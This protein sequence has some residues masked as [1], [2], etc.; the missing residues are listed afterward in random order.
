MLGLCLK[1]NCFCRALRDNLSVSTVL[2]RML[3]G[4]ELTDTLAKTV[5][6]EFSFLVFHGLGD[7]S[8][9]YRAGALLEALCICGSCTAARVTVSTDKHYWAKGTGFSIGSTASKWNMDTTLARQRS[10][11]KFVYV[12]FAIMAEYVGVGEGHAAHCTQDL[13]DIFTTSCLLPAM[14]SY[15]LNDSVLDISKH[16]PLYN[17]L[18]EL[19]F[20]LASNESLRHLLMLPVYSD[21]TAVSSDGNCLSSLLAKLGTIAKTYQKTAGVETTTAIITEG[22]SQPTTSSGGSEPDASFMR[23]L[24]ANTN[25]SSTE[26]PSNEE[27]SLNELVSK[28]IVTDDKVAKVVKAMQAEQI[29]PPQGPGEVLQL[30]TTVMDTPGLMDTDGVAKDEENIARIVRHVRKL[31]SVNAFCLVVNEQ[32]SRFDSGMQDAVKLLVDSFGP[33]CLNNMGIVFTKVYG[34]V[35]LEESKKNAAHIAALISRRT[36]FGIPYIP[37]WQLD[38]RPEQLATTFG[39]PQSEIERRVAQR[40]ATLLELLRWARASNPVDTTG[41]TAAEYEQRRLAREAEEKR[42]EA[43]EKRAYDQKVIK[44]DIEKRSVEYNRTSVPIFRDETRC[45][46]VWNG[47]LGPPLG[48]K[49]KKHFTERVHVGNTVTRFMREEQRK[50]ETLGSG[51]VIYGEWTTVREWQE[52]A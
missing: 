3:L 42:K 4:A 19:L 1:I 43:E 34:G 50:V 12:C 39:L 27:S 15:L 10:G 17:S 21:T 32:A 13:R 51:Q 46:K 52:N 31:A 26:L 2:L 47:P 48:L 20:C 23:L 36:G 22:S 16:I 38:C 11:E 29:S 40:D 41:A 8:L 14:A 25:A 7:L 28:I 6:Q 49:K 24:Q 45:R 9:Q 18:L 37:S 5:Q 35:S 30:C 33:N 44:T